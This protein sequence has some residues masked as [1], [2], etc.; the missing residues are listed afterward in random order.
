MLWVRGQ[1]D[2]TPSHRVKSLFW[3]HFYNTLSSAWAV[4]G[5]ETTLTR[6]RL[7]AGWETKLKGAS[8]WIICSYTNPYCQIG[9]L[10]NLHFTYR[11]TYLAPLARAQFLVKLGGMPP[12][13][14][15]SCDFF[16]SFSFLLSFFFLTICF[17]FNMLDPISTKLG[18]NDQ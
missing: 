10:Y 15:L 13:L 3:Y 17:F 12:N 11:L 2:V 1:P 5:W 8:H 14:F 6:A 4:A 7:V 18:Q 9:C 16:L